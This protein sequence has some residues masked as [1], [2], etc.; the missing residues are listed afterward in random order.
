MLERTAVCLEPCGLRVLPSHKKALQSTRQLHVAFWQHGAA[1]IELTKTWQALMHGTL[2]TTHVSDTSKSL[3]LNAS[4]FLLDFLYPTGA[5]ALLRRL[6][7][8][9]PDGS[10]NCRLRPRTSHV[11]HLYNS[12]IPRKQLEPNRT[13]IRNRGDLTEGNS[14]SDESSQYNT[15]P[16]LIES[17]GQG[18][19]DRS[20]IESIEHILQSED[21]E[22]AD[23]LWRHYKSLDEQTQN[24]ISRQALTFLSKTGRVSDYWK[25]SELFSNIDEANWDDDA[26]ISG[27]TAEV[28]LQNLSRALSIFERGLKS[29]VLDNTTLVDSLDLLLVAA[30]KSLTTEFIEEVWKLYP[31]MAARWNFDG[32]TADLKLLASVPGMADKAMMLSK[33]LSERLSDPSCQD[34]EREALQALQKILVRKA[35]FSC[36]N[37]QVLPLLLLTKDDLAFGEYLLAAQKRGGSKLIATDVYAVYRDLPGSVP[38]HAILHCVFDAYTGLNGSIS[39]IMAGVDLLWDDWHEFHGAPSR[40]AYQRHMGFHASRG[41]KERVY[42]LWTEYIERFREDATVDIFEGSDTFAH[43]LQVHAVNG[44]SEEA[45]RIFNDMSEKFKVQP[46]LYNWNIL[47]NSYAKADDYEG[48]LATFDELCKAVQPDQ[49]SYG[50][51]MQMAGGRGDLA[52]T[53][54]LYRRARNSGVA[55]NDAMLSS[56]VDA[57]C[58]N[59]HHREAEDVCTRAAEKALVAPRMWNKLL[60]YHALRRDLAS[61]NRIL[62]TMAD[63]S[64]PYNNYT[65]LQLLLG[66]TLC[67]QSHHALQ[68]LTVGLKESVFEVTPAHFNIVM[69]GLLR[70]GEPSLIKRLCLLMEEHGIAITED[71]MFRLSQA[72]TQWRDLP[73]QQRRQR[74]KRQW[75]GDAL[76]VFFQIYGYGAGLK[77]NYKSLNPKPVRAK[78][79]L[80]SGRDVYQFGTIAYI[81]AQL[82]D[83]VRVN[84][85]VGLYRYVF[86][87][88]S[89]DDGVLPLNM[90]NAVMLAALQDNRHNRVKSTWALLFDNVKQAARSA[91]YRADLPH[92]HKISP[93]FH[94]ALSGSLR[95]MQ[96]LLFREND[97]VGLRKLIDEVTEA[98][99]EID[100]KNWNYHVQILVQMKQY[101]PAFTICETTLMPNWTGWFA[102]RVKQAVRDSLPLDIRR[103]G[104]SPR[105][106]RPTAT[107]LYRLAQA[108]L[109]LDRLGPWSSEAAETLS[110]VERDSTQVIRAIKSMIRVHS[111]LE[112]ELFSSSE[113]G[114]TVDVS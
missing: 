74:T 93:K 84:E 45:Q 31:E 90:L 2:D 53:V 59:D 78:E 37:S 51:L 112:A 21:L 87:S 64:I 97:A 29:T 82:N 26:F 4:L 11:A 85:L 17:D 73:P 104:S 22:R 91:D 19:S 47:L 18:L 7:P 55:V 35:L 63:K 76:R 9:S 6:S 110:E 14:E 103:K 88:S 23:V 38:S 32:I 44:E 46:S 79:L 40:R 102:V 68:L 60:Y 86:Q 25:I 109:E 58:Q 95:V 96:E 75:V 89:S 16:V 49:Y 71:V 50:T 41:H 67:R 34:I 62:N 36:E 94:Y 52:F 65:Y 98:G 1:E 105:Y 81:F 15:P 43:L 10:F 69:G 92:T 99:F 42:T 33:Y 100:S 13:P 24:T 83:S 12:P 54:D 80:R 108:Y 107:T 28:N 101:K 39:K 30:F 66:L 114:D 72:L 111:D 106:L 70:T 48:A 20:H 3:S 27:I 5:I 77:A 61:I 113:L 8:V 57:Y 56:L